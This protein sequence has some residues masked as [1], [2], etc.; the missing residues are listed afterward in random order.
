MVR[1]PGYHCTLSGLFL[2]TTLSLAGPQLLP[3][4]N[5]RDSSCKPQMAVVSIKWLNIGSAPGE[6]LT[7]T[8]CLINVSLCFYFYYELFVE[9]L[10]VG[11]VRPTFNCMALGKSLCPSGPWF[12]VEEIGEKT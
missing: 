6:C 9:R 10:G 1:A 8:T 5:G 11:R 3:P 4:R 7:G 12:P 2:D